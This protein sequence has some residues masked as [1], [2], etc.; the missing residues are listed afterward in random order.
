MPLK[1]LY[2][3]LGQ[4][5]LKF[6]VGVM[7]RQVA[8]VAQIDPADVFQVVLCTPLQREYELGR[9]TTRGFYEEF[10]RQTGTRPDPGAL[11][12]AASDIFELNA[13]I[14]P[15]VT[16]L[17]HAGHR[18]GVLSNTCEGHWE[19]CMRRYAILR[20]LFDAYAL[21]YRIGAAKPDAAIF[22]AAARLA[23]VGP[24]EIF[25]TDD[26]PGH[27]EGAR[28]AGFD[29]VEYASTPNLVAQLETRGVR[30]NY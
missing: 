16:N 15:V 8:A 21:S 13:S 3:D 30:L 23:S 20:E 29:A 28:A 25:F 11:L 9:I 22:E 10:C 24:Q 1:F 14:I 17:R 19:H 2:F 27:V 5:L 26:V 6:D 4:V 7:C 12:G 18:L